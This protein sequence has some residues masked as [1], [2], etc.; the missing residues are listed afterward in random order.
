MPRPNFRMAF[1]PA[2]GAMAG[3]AV[4]RRDVLP[5]GATLVGPAIIEEAETSTIIAAAA[6]ISVDSLGCIGIA[7]SEDN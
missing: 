3:F 7:V 4:Y 2:A 1:L 5:A 6:E